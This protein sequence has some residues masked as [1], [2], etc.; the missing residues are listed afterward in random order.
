M[1]PHRAAANREGRGDRAIGLAC[2]HQGQHLALTPGQRDP[3]RRAVE[4]YARLPSA[5]LGRRLTIG[6]LKGI[7][8]KAPQD[9]R[10]HLREQARRVERLCQGVVELAMAPGVIQRYAQRRGVRLRPGGAQGDKGALGRVGAVEVDHDQRVGIHGHIL[11]CYRSRGAWSPPPTDFSASMTWRAATSTGA[12]GPIR[13][14]SRSKLCLIARRS[15][16]AIC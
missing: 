14:P 12:S 3:W 13:M 15:S 8:F 5:G 6:G 4:R 10:Q 16:R 1:Q 2:G 7:V 9:Q 11:A